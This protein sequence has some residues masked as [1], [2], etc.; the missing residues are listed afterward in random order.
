MIKFN[1]D[2][3]PEKALPLQNRVVEYVCKTRTNHPEFGLMTTWKGAVE[4]EYFSILFIRGILIVSVVERECQLGHVSVP[5]A[6]SMTLTH[7]IRAVDGADN[8][9][10]LEVQNDYNKNT[11][12]KEQDDITFDDVMECL[13]WKLKENVKVDED[14]LGD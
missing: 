1:V 2:A 7:A 11:S 12:Q 5:Y 13:K 6:E 4:N 14:L 8:S 3:P 10:K 9:V